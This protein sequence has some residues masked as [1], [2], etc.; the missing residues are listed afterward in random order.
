[1]IKRGSFQINSTRS[2]RLH[3]ST[4]QLF[5]LWWPTKT[6]G[7]RRRRSGGT[8]TE[9]VF[10]HK[11]SQVIL[12]HSDFMYTPSHRTTIIWYATKLD[13]WAKSRRNKERLAVGPERDAGEKGTHNRPDLFHTFARDTA[14]DGTKNSS[15]ATEGVKEKIKYMP[16][17]GQHVLDIC[18]VI[19]LYW[20]NALALNSLIFYSGQ[21]MWREIQSRRHFGARVSRRISSSTTTPLVPPYHVLCA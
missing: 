4:I 6:Q 10:V 12:L 1:M 3:I 18:T 2:L 13:S 20:F 9:S 14:S 7:K 19:K 15:P 5:I 17:M 11:T 16:Q 21:W 8:L